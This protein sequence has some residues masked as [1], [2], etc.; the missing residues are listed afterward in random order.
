MRLLVGTDISGPAIRRRRR[1]PSDTVG[2]VRPR[3]LVE[4]SFD[5]IPV[6]LTQLALLGPLRGSP[7]QT[8]ALP[9]FA[10]RAAMLWRGRPPMEANVPPV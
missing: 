9:V 4:D 6:L 1:T 10:S 3:V 8:L 7:S 5:L 2:R